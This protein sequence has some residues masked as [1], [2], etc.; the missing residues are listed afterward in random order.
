M[1]EHVSDQIAKQRGSQ[2][3]VDAAL[4]LYSDIFERELLLN[5]ERTEARERELLLR[6]A[7][8]QK[9]PNR[10]SSE[11]LEP[12]RHDVEERV[13]EAIEAQASAIEVRMQESEMEL[14]EE[15]SRQFTRERELWGARVHAQEREMSREH[16]CELK[17]WASRQEYRVEA[18][19]AQE[20]NELLAR[21]SSLMEQQLLE[22][23]S[24]VDESIQEHIRQISDVCQQRELQWAWEVDVSKHTTS[25]AWIQ[26]V[27]DAQAARERARATEFR[28]SEITKQSP[29]NIGLHQG[30]LHA[31]LGSG[32]SHPANAHS[33][34][35]CR[36][37]AL[38]FRCKRGSASD[39][40][41]GGGHVGRTDS[42]DPFENKDILHGEA[43]VECHGSPG[44]FAAMRPGDPRWTPLHWA[45]ANGQEA[46]CLQ[47]L[48]CSGDPY[49]R[50]CSG[51]TAF[52]Y[53]RMRNDENTLY[54]LF[55][56]EEKQALLHRP[57]GRCGVQGVHS[58]DPDGYPASVP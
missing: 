28:Q 52:D 11:Y 6:A 16:A 20:H 19:C 27:A 4:A 33:S 10:A 50:D 32:F 41:H 12:R 30:A 45:A 34:K 3:E 49:H 56:W 22:A 37:E 39:P 43:N 2:K 23:Q 38:E 21:S 53:A 46:I 26:R 54:V 44:S 1:G 57:A 14:R 24:F 40:P 31:R 48:Q 51:R 29:S 15:M 9:Q 47:L 7:A 13:R 58:T 5:I 8:R 17:A 25:E 55:D 36:T 18:L 42:S 35:D